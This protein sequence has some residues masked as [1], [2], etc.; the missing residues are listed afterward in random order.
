MAQILCY[1][2]DISSALLIQLIDKYRIYSKAG[3]K[4]SDDLNEVPRQ[5]LREIIAKYGKS[6][7]DDRERC[8]GLLKDYCSGYKLEVNILMAVLEEQVVDDLLNMSS[9]VPTEIHFSRLAKRVHDNRA[10]KE[11]AARW[12]VES[13]AFALGKTISPAKK[14]EERPPT[15]MAPPQQTLAQT[16]ILMPDRPTTPLTSPDPISSTPRPITSTPRPGAI[17]PSSSAVSGR[18]SSSARSS[19]PAV[20]KPIHFWRNFFLLLLSGVVFTLG[21]R[22]LVYLPFLSSL[23]A[24]N[25]LLPPSLFIVGAILGGKRGFWGTVLFLAVGIF[26]PLFITQTNATVGSISNYVFLY[27]GVKGISNLSIIYYLACPVVVAIVGYRIERNYLNGYWNTVWILI[28]GKAVFD[29]SMILS[30]W[31]NF[32]FSFS[33][34]FHFVLIAEPGDLLILVVTAVVVRM[35]NSARW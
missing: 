28:I 13:W 31:I 5:K 30:N 20:Q 1:L 34:S 27:Q 26:L 22:T 4:R 12:G 24:F 10:V 29:V 18:S 9:Q 11:D 32:H 16:Q 14:S 33:D 15:R 25:Y 2:L 23:N 35:I 17:S 7:C 6:V 21:S 3:E 19:S 8:K